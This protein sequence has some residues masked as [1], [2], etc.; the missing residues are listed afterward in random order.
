M[1]LSVIVI[2]VVIVGNGT[3]PGPQ[4]E[5]AGTA[6]CSPCV[7]HP[8][9]C[10]C[11]MHYTAYAGAVLR[12]V[13]ASQAAELLLFHGR[14]GSRLLYSELP[15]LLHWRSWCSRPLREFK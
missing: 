6:A 3:D 4:L 5:Q 1:L 13:G 15:P 7:H 10:W 12:A 14:L 11:V 9:A 8:T 2:Q